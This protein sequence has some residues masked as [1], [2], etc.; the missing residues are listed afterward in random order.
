LHPTVEDGGDEHKDLGSRILGG[1]G[2]CYNHAHGGKQAVTDVTSADVHTLIDIYKHVAVAD[3]ETI[4]VLFHF[5][6]EDSRIRSVCRREKQAELNVALKTDTALA[7][8]V[9]GWTPRSSVRI[10][11][12][13][14]AHQ[15][16]FAGPFVWTGKMPAG[17]CVTVQYALPDKQT[18]EKG[19]GKDFEIF[20]RGDDV[21]GVRP[22]TSFYPF[23]ADAPKR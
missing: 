22:N 8:R 21:A 9:P 19:L 10:R 5:D 6:Y 11:L 12:G 16:V 14:E 3:G 23:Y 17:S 1:Y 18:T 20:W 7:I 13:S 15:P 2:G 4:E